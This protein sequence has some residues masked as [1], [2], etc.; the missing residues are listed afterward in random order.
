MA[1]IKLALVFLFCFPFSAKSAQNC[2]LR[3]YIERSSTPF[4]EVS[5][6]IPPHGVTVTRVLPTVMTNPRLTE[7]FDFM[8]ENRIVLTK[9]PVPA[10]VGE[11]TT[12]ITVGTDALASETLLFEHLNAKLITHF[13]NAPVNFERLPAQSQRLVQR[14]RENFN[15]RFIYEGEISGRSYGNRNMIGVNARHPDNLRVNAAVSHEITHN[16]T[17]RKIFESFNPVA[18]RVVQPLTPNL[19]GRSM[20]FRAKSGSSMDLPSSLSAYDKFMGSDEIEAMLREMA[21]AKKDG[22]SNATSLIHL[23]QFLDFQEQNIRLLLRN[24]QQDFK[25][26][27]GEIIDELRAGRRQQRIVTIP[28]A[29]F[30]IEVL[31]PTGL[32]S[33]QERAFIQRV[34]QERLTTF[35]GYRSSIQQ[36]FSAK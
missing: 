10:G 9:G 13:D 15:T 24:N 7:L 14:M 16:T 5:F 12:Y 8:R 3:N 2:F 4:R 36:R 27:P 18:G 34:L 28:D 31:V 17:D 35:Q 19:A 11:G 26:T 23:N 32:S 1:G 25:F 29:N 20:N 21:Q 30:Q 33:A 6:Q 22:L